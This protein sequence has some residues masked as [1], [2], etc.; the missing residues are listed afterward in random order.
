M[1]V[2]MHE[3]NRLPEWAVDTVADLPSLLTRA[4]A[5]NCLRL[6]I[7]SVDRLLR[8]GRLHAVRTAGTGSG[9]VLIPRRALA[10]LLVD[11][12]RAA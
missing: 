3:V 2:T 1:E 12:S 5:A 10:T 11:M 8:S 9:R 6:H 7:S 4:G